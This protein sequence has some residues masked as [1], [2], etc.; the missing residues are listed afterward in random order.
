MHSKGTGLLVSALISNQWAGAPMGHMEGAQESQPCNASLPGRS[1]AGW[2]SRPEHRWLR[3]GCWRQAGLAGRAVQGLG[4][5][6]SFR[7]GEADSAETH[8]SAQ[9]EG[10]ASV[11][12][13]PWHL[14]SNEGW[15][16]APPIGWAPTSFWAPLKRTGQVAPA[17]G[18][19]FTP[20]PCY[21]TPVLLA[22]VCSHAGC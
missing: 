11:A 8:S 13:V 20:Q 9:W 5:G 21:L 19:V 4:D 10:E 7:S 14:S 3:Q 12:W 15:G 18:P 2:G 16:A 1:L 17:L 22:K 6:T